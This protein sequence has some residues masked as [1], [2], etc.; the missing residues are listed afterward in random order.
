[1]ATPRV[2][3]SFLQHFAPDSRP[4]ISTVRMLGKITSIHGDQ[5]TLE[6][7]Q[8]ETVTLIMNRWIAI[9]QAL[10]V[11]LNTCIGTLTSRCT[12][13]TRSWARLS[14][15]REDRGLDS[16]YLV[17]TVCLSVKMGRALISKRMR[18]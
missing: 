13:T 3:P 10:R 5:A 2:L 12:H 11:Q 9:S 4:S 15:L 16:G 8:N 1:M 17:P 18:P 6:S 7:Y 14:I